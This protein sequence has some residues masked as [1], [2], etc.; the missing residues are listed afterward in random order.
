MRAAGARADLAQRRVRAA[1]AAAGRAE[2]RREAHRRFQGMLHDEVSTAL[3]AISLPGVPVARL[4]EAA[5]GAVAALAAAPAGPGRKARTD[6]A[7]VVRALRPPPGTV[8]AIEA[9]GP[10]LVPPEVADAAAGAAREALRNVEEHAGAR[11]VRLRLRGG[12][13]DRPGAA[14]DGE[15][16]LSITDDGVGFAAGELAASSVGLRRSVIRRMAAVGG[17]AEVRSAPGHG[18]TVRLEWRPPAA[19]PAADEADEAET[20]AGT[21]GGPAGGPTG[22][23]ADT[24]GRM[25]AAVGDVRRPLAAV[26][27]P[28]LTAMGVIAA[29]HT[30][31]TPGTGPLLVWYALLTALTVALLL[32]AASGIPALVAGA[33]CAFAVAGALGSFLVLPLASL[34]DYTSWPVGAVTPLLTLLVIVRPAWE[35]LTALALEQVGIAVLVATGPPIAPSVGATMALLLPALLSPALGVITGLALGRTVAR[36]GGVTA[37]AEADRSASLATEAARR[38]REELHQGR[39]ADLGQ[40]ILPFLAATGSGRCAPDD[41]GVRDRARLLAGAVRDEIHLPGVLDR[42][43]RELLSAAR[44]AGCVVTIQSDS[45][46]PHP[47]AFLRLLLTTALTC[48]PTPRELVLTVNAAAGVAR[49]SLVVLPGDEWRARALREAVAGAGAGTG[50]VVADS[51]TS[52]WVEADVRAS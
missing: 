21:V 44:R 15:F 43:V 23:P 48:A 20:G 18:T 11:S 38:A 51:A 14:A 36:L 37:R 5:S 40:E 39:L 13:P 33:A 22:V 7:A 47:P 9:T 28:F 24:L 46:D 27:L 2:G 16:T 12:P 25:R 19:G 31:R 3:Q 32:R 10:A 49:A 30:A 8:L 50:V 29:I 6:L 17:H 26:C 4:R 34:A 41:P 35:A 52:T 42:T 45:D 1:R